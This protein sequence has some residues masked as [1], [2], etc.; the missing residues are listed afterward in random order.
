MP[1]RWFSLYRCSNV[2]SETI[3]SFIWLYEHLEQKSIV[4]HSNTIMKTFSLSLWDLFGDVTHLTRLICCVLQCH[5]NLIYKIWNMH[6]WLHQAPVTAWIKMYQHPNSRWSDPVLSTTC[7]QLTSNKTT[8]LKGYAN[9]FSF[10]Y[11]PPSWVPDKKIDPI[12]W[13][14]CAVT[15]K[16]RAELTH[17]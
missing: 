10:G 7:P 4:L 1:V 5:F 14:V 12:L 8:D 17:R 11:L 2:N 15:R 13:T 6:F 9:F 3:S 16:R